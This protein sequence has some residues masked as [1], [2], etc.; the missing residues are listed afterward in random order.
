MKHFFFLIFPRKG[1]GM[2]CQS[3]FFEKKK[4]IIIKII[5]KKKKS[6]LAQRMVKV[7]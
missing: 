2:K 4:I 1:F 7:N 3:L 5:I 6:E